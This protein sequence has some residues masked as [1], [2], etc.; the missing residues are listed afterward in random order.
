MLYLIYS[1][2][3]TQNLLLNFAFKILVI[4]YF[5]WNGK[6]QNFIIKTV[7]RKLLNLKS[8]ESLVYIF[9]IG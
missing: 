8:L 7:F 9:Y 3:L 6:L 5:L 4:Y 2:L 1:I